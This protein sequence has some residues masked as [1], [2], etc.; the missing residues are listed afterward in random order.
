MWKYIHSCSNFR[1]MCDLWSSERT[2]MR[3]T[4]SRRLDSGFK[5][6]SGT[7]QASQSL[8]KSAGPQFHGQHKQLRQTAHL[9]IPSPHL[10]YKQDQ[11]GQRSRAS[12]SPHTTSLKYMLLKYGQKNFKTYSARISGPKWNHT[13]SRS[14]LTITRVL[15]ESAAVEPMVFSGSHL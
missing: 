4:V 5:L 3:D 14:T 15:L 6:S 9:H 7:P 2:A 13:Y 8:V 10:L 1:V 11:T 12:T